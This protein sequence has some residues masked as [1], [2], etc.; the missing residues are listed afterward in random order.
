[1][2]E[3]TVRMPFD[4]NFD[5]PYGE[6]ISVAPRIAR[7][8]APNPGPFTFKGTG[9]YIVGERDV[10]VIDPGPDVRTHI[11]ALKRALAGKRVTHILVT[12]THRDHSPAAAALKALCGANTYAYG[13]HPSSAGDAG[14]K[15]E[16][17]DDLNFCPDVCVKD[18]GVLSCDGFTIECVFTPGHMSN[19]M[20]YALPEEKALFTGDHVMGWS[21]T[22]V[23]PPDGNMAAYRASL[24]KLLARDD[25]TFWPTHGGP[26]RD[27]K[28]LLRAY[29]D[30]RAEREGQIL[31]CLRDGRS[32]IP[33]IVARL[34]ADVDKRLHPAA[35]RT[36]LAHLIQLENEKRARGNGD[37]FALV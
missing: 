14:A 21:T 15:I 1:M 27:P 10:A 11:E 36:V 23:A 35:A 37:V 4:R 31:A 18:G 17:G 13:P 19:H 8:L 30:H 22:V 7:L 25:R 32:T 28:T 20:C 9:V 16:E 33:D 34:Y 26:V 3:T 5:A 29:R 6:C 2:A 12:H 24:E